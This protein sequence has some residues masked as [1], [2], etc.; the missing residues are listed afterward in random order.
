[1]STKTKPRPELA[2]PAPRTALDIMTHNVVSVPVGTTV[3]QVA[4]VLVKNRISA[5]PVVDG[6]GA[7]VG[8]VSEGDL[9]GRNAQDRLAGREWWLSMLADPAEQIAIGAEARARLVEDVMHAP[10]ITA[11]MRTPIREVADMLQT[12]KIKRVVVVQD[13]HPIGIVSRAD[14]MRLAATAAVED[15]SSGPNALTGM[16]ASFFGGDGGGHESASAPSRPVPPPAPN[17][18]DAP[19]AKAFRELV[20]TFKHKTLD[21][22]AKASHE[23]E[24]AHNRQIKD[25]LQEHLNAQMW[26]T[27]LEHAREVAVHGENEFQL[28]RFPSDLCSDEGRM[29]RVHEKGWEKTLRGEA[30][31]LFDRWERDLKERGFGLS[32]RV[33]SFPG[34]MPGDIGLFL[35]WP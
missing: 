23:A 34:G 9:L 2:S 35:T 5:V 11:T 12:H 22:R 10:V 26:T 32:A 14:L 33:V 16:L 6:S 27:L 21:A 13:L 29:I 18:A 25:L 24:L 19:T 30:A 17:A 3:G 7:L 8:I 31:D 1:M 28:L 20:E 15:A 4:Q